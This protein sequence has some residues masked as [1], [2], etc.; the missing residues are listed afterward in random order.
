MVRWHKGL[1]W[2]IAIGLVAGACSNGSTAKDTKK[3]NGASESNKALF[4]QDELNQPAHEGEPKRGGA[5]KFGTEAAILN[6]SPNLSVVQ[7]PDLQLVLSVFDPLVTYDDKGEPVGLLATSIENSDDFK[8]WTLKLRNDVKFSNGV[9]LDANQVVEHTKWLQASPSCSCATDA[10][11]IESVSAPDASTVVYKLRE[12]NVAWP[13]KLA[14]N[15]GWIS[16]NGARHEAKNADSPDDA[17]LIGTG[18]FMFAGQDGNKYIVKRN[19]N[20]YGTDPLNNDAK[21]PYLDQITFVPLADAGT[22]LAAVRSG[23]VDIMQTAVTSTL[24]EA[25]ADPKLK[26][27]PSS[28]SSATILILNMS[29]PPFGVEPKPGESVADTVNRSLKDPIASDARRA[30]ALALNRNEI[31]Q[32]YYKGTRIPAYGPIAPSNPYF[33]EKGQLPRYNPD[34]A[35][36]LVEK[37]KKAGVDFT[38]NSICIPT[39]ESSGVFNVMAPQLEDVGVKST[40]KGVDQA[41]LVETLLLGKENTSTANWNIS[42]FRS[43]QLADPDTLYNGLH[44]GGAGNINHYSNSKV[45]EA[46]EQGRAVSGLQ[47]RKPFYD[48]VQQQSAKD[49]HIVPLLFDLSGN[50]YSTRLSGLGRPSPAALALIPTRGLYLVK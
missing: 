27:Q 15:L 29:R 31:N 3:R 17:H 1:V 8:T 4:S 33:D 40:R 46:L 32:K 50:V 36:E 49:V 6:T 21:L 43:A 7:P 23:G 20:Y 19:P 45:D 48:I 11:N 44:T 9:P 2:L 38:V 30:F 34:E 37:V 10:A 22:R 18:P 35:R 16:E 41:V 47:A 5:I 42:C 25:K 13:T 28:G 26:V 12:G 14:S 39:P 24:V